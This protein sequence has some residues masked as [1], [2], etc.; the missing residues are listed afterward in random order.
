[1]ETSFS[2]FAG[3]F[4]QGAMMTTDWKAVWERKA[5]TDSDDQ[6]DISGFEHFRELDTES[7]AQNICRLMDA[8][9]GSSILEIGRAAGL[10][11][12]ILNQSYAYVGS[13]ACA[14]MV[15]K[16]IM[17]N[18]FSAV[19]CD[20][21]D[22][23]FK[24]KTFDYVFAFSVFHYFPDFDYARRAISEMQRVARK[25]VCVSDVPLASHDPS[26][27]LYKE[28]FFKGWQISEGLYSRE[29]KRFTATLKF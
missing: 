25:A 26:H 9:P 11:G 23:I 22:I 27:L 28:D 19:R 14:S 20:A 24:D 15:E 5:K 21:D 2:G 3:K 10:I 13:D 7:A 8:Q 1:V 6:F 17:L 4:N 18:K 12:R 16:T 29:H